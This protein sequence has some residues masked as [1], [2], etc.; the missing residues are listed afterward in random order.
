MHKFSINCIYD[1]PKKPKSTFDTVG[2]K[3]LFRFEFLK[4]YFSNNIDKQNNNNNSSKTMNKTSKSRTYPSPSVKKPS[5][6]SS[7]LNAV[8]VG[9]KS[10]DIL[11]KKKLQRKQE[12]NDYLT[13]D[14][15]FR[16]S[17]EEL[18]KK[19]Q[20]L[21]SKHNILSE[22]YQPP[23]LKTKVKQL[24]TKIQHLT[25]NHN[26][27]KEKDH[28][29]TTTRVKLRE[30]H[31]QHERERGEQS[32]SLDLLELDSDEE[33]E[34]DEISSDYDHVH[35]QNRSQ[36]VRKHSNIADRSSSPVNHA[37][38]VR[39]LPFKSSKQQKSSQKKK[40]F[41]TTEKIPDDDLSTISKE[42]ILLFQELRYYEEL[43][44]KRSILQTDVSN[45]L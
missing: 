5:T 31:Q 14:N 13:E 7:N 38:T 16:I 30:E 44:G 27:T 11:V 25:T 37:S 42:L 1:F 26:N 3:T 4:R 6:S 45:I 15:Q 23:K 17:P 40:F 2:G 21:V 24:K 34:E 36:S 32:T 28:T 22:Q 12:W 20:L 18:L 19:K 9:R 33:T 8:E 35:H 41:S 43:S 29:P 10:V 39:N